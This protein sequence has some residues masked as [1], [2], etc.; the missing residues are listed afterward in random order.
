[1]IFLHLVF[2]NVKDHFLKNHFKNNG[3]QNSFQEYESLSI[4]P[5]HIQRTKAEHK[6]ALLIL[7]HEIIEALNSTK[8]TANTKIEKVLQI[9]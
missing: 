3:L 7:V 2:E 6:Q 4:R 9:A 8:P 1:M 5:H